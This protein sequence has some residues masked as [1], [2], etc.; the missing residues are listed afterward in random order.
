MPTILQST[1]GSN[2]ARPWITACLI[3][4]SVR[5]F[6]ADSLPIELLYNEKTTTTPSDLKITD[7][8]NILAANETRIRSGRYTVVQHGRLLHPPV[9]FETEPASISE[10]VTQTLVFNDTLYRTKLLYGN[11][12]GTMTFDEEW[13]YDGKELR[14]LSDGRK[15]GVIRKEDGIAFDKPN[16]FRDLFSPIGYSK[17][18]L[19]SV[20]Y[21]G[22]EQKAP[23]VYKLYMVQHPTR[24][25]LLVCDGY[26]GVLAFFDPKE[27]Y[28]P[29]GQILFKN[30][31]KGQIF[32]AWEWMQSEKINGVFLPRTSAWTQFAQTRD[33]GWA[34]GRYDTLD[35]LVWDV[36]PPVKDSEFELKFPSTYDVYDNIR[37][38]PIMA[39]RPTGKKYWIA[40][41]CAAAFAVA[42]AG[43]RLRRRS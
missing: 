43:W 9:P 26:H 37:R 6:A 19:F 15:G 32:V 1:F 30:R 34:R 16:R 3:F 10:E 28:A 13:A 27:D 7:L 35:F 21:T 29:V 12:D 14:S 39:Q 42:V 5:V 2:A 38:K 8:I 20:Y 24:G 4:W 25:Q 11:L 36:N 41:V 40:A 23:G 31:D 18:G 33:N 22:I 17:K